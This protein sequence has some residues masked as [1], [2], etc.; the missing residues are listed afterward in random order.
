MD[1]YEIRSALQKGNS[2]YDL[3]L[4]V[5]F[6]ARVSTDKDE[7]LHSL[8]A[9]AS[10]YTNLIQS[11][12]GWEYV[13][14]YID[15]GISGASVRKRESFLQMIEDAKN[16]K[17]DFILTKEISR[18]SRNTLDSI[19]YTQDLLRSGVGI[20]FQNDNINTLLPDAELR[21]TIMASIAQ[22][23]VRKLSERV[24]F[25]FQRAIEKGVVLGN[26]SIW[27]YRKSCGTLVIEDSEAVWIRKIFDLYANQNY[28]IRAICKWLE[29]EGIY[30]HN[31]NRFSFTTVRNILR[32]PKYKGYYCGN[33]SHKYDYK[34]SEVKELLPEEWVVYRDEERVPPIVSE[35]LW[36]KANQILNRRGEEKKAKGGSGGNQRY[37]Y[38]GKIYCVADGQV[39]YRRVSHSSGKDTELWRCRRYLT[40]GK[41]KCDTPSVTTEALDGVIKDLIGTRI[42]AKEVMVKLYSIYLECAEQ[43]AQKKELY[44]LQGEINRLLQR[45]DRLLDLNL[46][47]RID[48]DEFSQRNVQ[49]NKKISQMKGRVEQ[50]LKEQQDYQDSS[51]FL[52]KV[53][54]GTRRAL[55]FVDQIPRGLVEEMIERITVGRTD[56]G[57][58]EVCF[59]LVG[60]CTPVRTEYV[61][62]KLR[63]CHPQS[64]CCNSCT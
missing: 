16:G 59:Y 11:H 36:E 41:E 3:K 1:L 25:G 63:I 19:Q 47:G 57:A 42:D 6:Y 4:R 21:L 60:E 49:Y 17:F 48:D 29:E 34:L 30:N 56:R 46:D 61:A 10:Y 54:R 5:T 53:A 39:F 58:T 27:G 45:K 8:Q 43:G 35:T 9:Q 50:I 38:S 26:S 14:G 28:G 18:F 23:E 52:I 40:D 51:A 32:N 31:G 33:K 12:P 24:R 44:R 55:L 20:Y 15:E 13:P 22:D 7:Q 37:S 62:K 2:I 64:L